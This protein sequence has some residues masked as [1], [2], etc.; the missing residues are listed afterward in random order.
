MRERN[1]SNADATVFGHQLGE[2]RLNCEDVRQRTTKP[3]ART[4]RPR[5]HSRR[6]S[7][8]NRRTF[9]VMAVHCVVC[10][11]PSLKKLGLS[12]QRR[13]PP[14]T[15]IGTTRIHDE[16]LFSWKMSENKRSNNIPPLMVWELW[17]AGF[18]HSV[19]LRS[20]C[21]SRANFCSDAALESVTSGGELQVC[22]FVS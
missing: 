4:P 17:C 9:D 19:G 22:F 14:L 5:H 1:Q 11:V 16:T 12:T 15:T 13:L 2:L 3:T 8:R 7:W 21:G 18:R 10:P 6:T 20:H